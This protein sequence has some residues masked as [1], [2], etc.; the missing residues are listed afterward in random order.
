MAY[1][2]VWTTLANEDFDN[3]IEYIFG[4][5]SPEKAINFVQTFYHKLDLLESM[6]FIGIKSEKR[7]NIRKLLITRY[8][9]LIYS[10]VGEGIVLLSIIDTR[11]NPNLLKF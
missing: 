6:P 1:K 8:N 11:Q 3:I 2:I 9:F 5:W 7:E 10:V 4:R